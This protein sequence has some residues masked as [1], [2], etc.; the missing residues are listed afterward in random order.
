VSHFFFFLIPEF[1]PVAY[2]FLTSLYFCQDVACFPPVENSG[3]S[4]DCIP[5]VYPEVEV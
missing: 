2:D 1:C 5:V 3:P 4:C